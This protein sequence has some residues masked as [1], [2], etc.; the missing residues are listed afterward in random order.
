[1]IKKWGYNYEDAKAKCYDAAEHYSPY[2]VV[3]TDQGWDPNHIPHDQQWY[4]VLWIV[5]AA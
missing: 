2:Q 3:G 4:Y 5:P 1:M